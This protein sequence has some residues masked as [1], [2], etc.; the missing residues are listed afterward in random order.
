MQAPTASKAAPAKMIWPPELKTYVQ[1]ALAEEFQVRGVTTIEVNEQL[2]KTIGYFAERAMLFE[3]DWDNYPL[4]QDIIVAERAK[5]AEQAAANAAFTN[6]SSSPTSTKR[7]AHDTVESQSPTKT[8][9]PPWQ[10]TN[11]ADRVTFGNGQKEK[12]PKQDDAT[13]SKS[14]LEK[15]RKRFQLG[16]SGKTKTTTPPWNTQNGPDSDLSSGPVVGTN[17]NLEKSYFRLTAPPKAETVR[18]QPV[19]ERTL[20]MLRKKWKGEEKNYNYICNQFKSLRQDLTVQHIKN[21][22]TVKVYEMHARIALE[23]G[24]LGEYNQC[25]TQLRVLYMQKLGGHPAEFL[26]YR[27]LYF[28]YTCNK[29]D[30]NDLLAELTNADKNQ[31]AVR[32]ALDVRSALALGNYHKFFRLYLEAPNM[33]AYLMDMFIVRER[34]AAL[35]NISRA[36]MSIA[37]RFLT[38][39]LGFENDRECCAFLE[40]HNAQNMIEEKVNDNGTQLRVNFKGAAPHFEALRA[41]AFSKVDIKGQ[42]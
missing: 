28:V 29:A 32:H 34:L 36:Y 11:L 7:K 37:L 5:L 2:K 10:K 22:F 21:S 39:E 20:D 27:I 25:Q 12:R 30:M 42:I 15:R 23:K 19:L 13:S 31:D 40:A 35:A 14:D 6:N 33:G 17:Q 41:A 1:R 3:L 4:P 9:T 26:A 24:D 18:P 8:S 38:D 16:T